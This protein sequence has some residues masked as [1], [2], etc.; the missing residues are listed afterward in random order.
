MLHVVESVQQVYRIC[1]V[2]VRNYEPYYRR[3]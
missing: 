1:A 3:F 2:L